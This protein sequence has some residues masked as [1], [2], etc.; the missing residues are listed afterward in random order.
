MKGYMHLWRIGD[1]KE[2]MEIKELYIKNFGKFSEQHFLIQEGIHIF[3]GENEYGKSTIYAFIKAML[4]GLERARGKAALNDEFRRYEPWDNPNYYAGVIRFRCGE[5]F[6]RLERRF[7]RY[8]KGAELICENDGE[9]L[10]VEQGDLDILLEGMTAT[11]FQNIAA[12][13]QLTAKPGQSLASELQ[14]YAANSYE[15]GSNGVDLDG[16]RQAL[17]S[18]KKEVEQKIKRLKL[19]REA[20]RE[21]ILEKIADVDAEIMQLKE[22]IEN[23]RYVGSKQ[24]LQQEEQWDAKNIKMLGIITF[25]ILVVSLLLKNIFPAL[26]WF[27][28]GGGI[29]GMQIKKRKQRNTSIKKENEK[30]QQKI[31]WEI[32]YIKDVLKE[33]EIVQ[34]NLREDLEEL[35]DIPKEERM[36]KKTWSAL[37]LS[38]KTLDEASRSMSKGFGQLLN[39]KASE[40]LEQI[41]DGKYNR[42]FI[43]NGLELV[44]LT[45]GKRIQADRLSR[46]TLEQIYFSLRMAILDILYEDKIPV[47]FDDAFAFYDDKRLKSTLKW[48]REQSRQVIIFSCQKRETEILDELEEEQFKSEYSWEGKALI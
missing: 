21:K 48:L 2:N 27:V 42:L 1:K 33:K 8:T 19:E 7:D 35:E 38:E 3:Y 30:I 32:Q 39:E 4:F 24:E 23:R 11:S 40:I 14:N 18:R 43:E 34:N 25:I 28:L 12:I 10:S 20:K 6:F 5:R 37:E 13:G 41:T 31:Q 9:E 36:L 44:V 29:F 45:Q 26:I 17:K 16:T 22:K 46:G 15:T 47:I